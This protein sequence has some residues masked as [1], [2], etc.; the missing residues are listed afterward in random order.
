MEKNYIIKSN[1]NKTILSH[2][3]KETIVC[4]MGK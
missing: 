1:E 4:Q 3:K 2:M